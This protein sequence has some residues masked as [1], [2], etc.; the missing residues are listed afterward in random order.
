VAGVNLTSIHKSKAIWSDPETFRP[1]RFL[2]S[3][4]NVINAHK[5]LPFGLGKR[6]CLGEALARASLFSY[7]TS[8]M[9]RYT[10]TASP[11][12][13]QPNKEPVYGFT[14]SAQEYYVTLKHR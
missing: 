2:D 5:I 7:F 6:V 9:Q 1:E 14:L 13:P 3:N 8:L 10:F 12:H 4:N 11:K